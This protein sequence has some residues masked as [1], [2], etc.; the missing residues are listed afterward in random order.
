MALFAAVEAGTFE[1]CA[2]ITGVLYLFDHLVTVLLCVGPK[3]P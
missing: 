3:G 1:G 2:I